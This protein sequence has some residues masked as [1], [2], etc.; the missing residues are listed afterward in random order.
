MTTKGRKNTKFY[1]GVLE[2]AGLGEVSFFLKKAK[3]N[4]LYAA[5]ALEN[6]DFSSLDELPAI[7]AKIVRL[8]DFVAEIGDDIDQAEQ[9][10]V[11]RA[12]DAPGEKSE[13]GDENV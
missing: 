11:T 9:T 10:L 8:R 7:Q 12:S 1:K 5:M 2:S 3:Q 6:T 13:E 4:I